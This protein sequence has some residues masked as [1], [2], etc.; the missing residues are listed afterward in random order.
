MREAG[1]RVNP[2][3]ICRISTDKGACEGLIRARFS[4]KHDHTAIFCYCD[5]VAYEAYY[6]LM[7]LGRAVP[8]EVAVAG[9]DDLSS[10]ITMPIRI[11]SAGYDMQAMAEQSVDL[12]LEKI[13]Y[14]R[15]HNGD[16]S[17]WQERLLILSQHLSIGSPP[18]TLLFPF[19]TAPPQFFLKIWFND[20]M[21]IAY[22]LHC[23]L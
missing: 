21:S 8:G 11:T 9:V 15:R 18:D 1:L 20:C 14:K 2:K 16:G 17:L 5:V 7:E 19:P 13:N 4:G 10:Y 3:D 23:F 22:C 12:L 6:T